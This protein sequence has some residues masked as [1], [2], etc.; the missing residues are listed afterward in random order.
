MEWL[1]PYTSV[2]LPPAVAG[3]TNDDDF[4]LSIGLAFGVPQ[5]KTKFWQSPLNEWAGYSVTTSPVLCTRTFFGLR[6]L[7]GDLMFSYGTVTDTFSR[8]LP[9]LLVIWAPVVLFERIWEFLVAYYFYKWFKYPAGLLFELFRPT[10]PEPVTAHDRLPFWQV[11]CDFIEKVFGFRE[12]RLFWR[13][14]DWVWYWIWLTDFRWSY[15]I[16]LFVF[17]LQ[18]EDY[19]FLPPLAV[20]EIG[21]F[22]VC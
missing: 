13:M 6:L 3:Y 7:R 16:V 5:S 11:L 8:L 12:L 17:F 20:D 19:K 14:A 9:T 18:F 4:Y 22:K 10:F 21:D 15:W 2:I 1:D